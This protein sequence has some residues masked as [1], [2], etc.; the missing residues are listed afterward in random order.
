MPTALL[1]KAFPGESEL[2][3][4]LRRAEAT[5]RAKDEF[6]AV[7]SHELRTP[8]SAILLWARMLMSGTLKPADQAEALRAIVRS[9]EVQNQ[10]VEDLFDM[11][12]LS[13][14]A[15][16]LER[17]LVVMAETVAST[18]EGL[19][20]AADEKAVILT[21]FCDGPTSVTVSADPRRLQQIVA[22]LVSNA[23]KF[24]PAGGHVDVTLAATSHVARLVVRD[25]GCGIAPERL[26]CLFDPVKLAE[27]GTTQRRDGMGLGLSIVNQLVGLH[28][29]A[30][31]VESAGVGKGATF[32]V[33]LLLSSEGDALE[34]RRDAR[35]EVPRPLA[36]VRVL[37][38]EDH[39]D[40][41]RA[42]GIALESGGAQVIGV[43]SASHAFV[44]ATKAPPDVIVSDICMPCEDGLS[45]LRRLHADAEAKQRPAPIALAL[46]AHAGDMREQVLASGFRA[47]VPKPVD[48]EELVRMVATLY[49]QKTARQPA[50]VEA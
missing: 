36:G 24:T 34:R 27:V 2:A 8:T 6:L 32:T 42:L 38:V 18:V 49:K 30:F 16:Q 3:A 10:L 20:R 28:G 47:H 15:L 26:A 13:R 44:A 11:A 46:T 39:A 9:A 43:G 22:N 33:E 17:R 21:F 4:R 35:E 40:T 5:I 31:G 12:R 25:T 7:L 19:R 29:G 41:R 45:L 23:I 50:E 1:E 14:D 48:P 37:L